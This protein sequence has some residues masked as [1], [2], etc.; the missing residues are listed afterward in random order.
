MSKYC[1]ISVTAL[2]LISS[3]IG[4]ADI[5]V[6]YG[7][8]PDCPPCEIGSAGQP[9]LLNP[10]LAGA[11]QQFTLNSAV[12]LTNI[13]FWTYEEPGTYSIPVE[14][15]FTDMSG[16]TVASGTDSNPTRSTPLLVPDLGGIG[17]DMQ[18]SMI[19][20]DL[21]T[22]LAIGQDPGPENYALNLKFLL[23]GNQSDTLFYWAQGTNNHVA[24]Q[25]TDTAGSN[26]T[27]TVPEPSYVWFAAAGLGILIARRIRTKR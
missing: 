13:T 19:S 9:D 6:N 3:V 23:P 26:N 24:F 20:L 27:S 2:G 5:V 14:W 10:G 1:L 21:S 8:P 17:L 25:L 16:N 7:P 15:W 11:S 18:V 12:D 4:R 22:P